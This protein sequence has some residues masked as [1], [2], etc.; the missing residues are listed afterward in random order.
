MQNYYKK[1]IVKIK[2]FQ[3]IKMLPKKSTMIEKKI[4]AA[5]YLNELNT[6]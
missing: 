4:A 1:K 2:T 3:L 5:F 6:T